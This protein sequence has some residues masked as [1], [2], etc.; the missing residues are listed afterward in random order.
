MEAAGVRGSMSL[1][2]IDKQENTVELSLNP[3]FYPKQQVLIAA[4]DFSDACWV[5]FNESEKGRVSVS[6][7]PKKNETELS[8]VGYEFLNY[9]LSLVKAR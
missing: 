3:D 6:L 2:S 7:K 4:Q 9:L 5:N 1:V 8:T